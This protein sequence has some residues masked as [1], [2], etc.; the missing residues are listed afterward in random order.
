MKQMPDVQTL[1]AALWAVLALR[2]TRRALKR[3]PVTEIRVGRPPALPPTAGRG[4]RAILRRSEPTCLERALVLQAWAVAQGE[5]R[6]VVIG[7]N[8]TGKQFAAHAWLDG[9]ADGERGPYRE[10]MRVPAS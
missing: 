8:G 7:V 5:A 6:D 2:R 10:L 4:V 1:R 9:D 3:G